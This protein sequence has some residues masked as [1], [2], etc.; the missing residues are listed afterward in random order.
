MADFRTHLFSHLQSLS[1]GFF[2]RRRTGELMSRL[3]NDVGALQTTLT[4]IPIGLAKQVV[5]LVGGLT[6]LFVMNWRLCLLILLLLPAIVLVARFFGRRLKALSTSIQDETARAST[7]LEEVL[8]GI[9]IVKSF[10]RED[11][12]LARFGAQVRRTLDIV[13]RRARIMPG[14]LPT[15]TFPTL[16]APAMVPASGAAP[17]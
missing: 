16:A 6:I 14:F 13:L 11:Y 1:L 10:V 5:T 8:S 4:E 9:R 17:S 15:I 3:M 2:A 7:I 12:E